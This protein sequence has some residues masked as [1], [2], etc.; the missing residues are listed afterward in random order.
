MELPPPMNFSLEVFILKLLISTLFLLH[1]YIHSYLFHDALILLPLEMATMH[2]ELIALKGQMDIL[3]LH[4]ALLPEGYSNLCSDLSILYEQYSKLDNLWYPS[5]GQRGE[6]LQACESLRI[7]LFEWSSPK[8]LGLDFI[9]YNFA[10]KE[11]PHLNPLETLT[12][13]SLLERLNLEVYLVNQSLGLE[14]THFHPPL[15][16]EPLGPGVRFSQ[17]SYENQRLSILQQQLSFLNSYLTSDVTSA[18]NPGWEYYEK[19]SV[20]EHKF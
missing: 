18:L 9:D 3:F 20:L 16:S 10:L 7:A 19:I 4:S 14:L 15:G 12:Q 2:L 8:Y 6:N 5:S 1:F 11:C 17:M 13:S